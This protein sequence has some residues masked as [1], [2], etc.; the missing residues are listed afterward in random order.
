M[1]VQIVAGLMMLGGAGMILVGIPL[2][3]AL[4]LGIIPIALGVL[5]IWCALG[6]FK[7]KKQSYTIAL[8]AYGISA[9][10]TLMGMTSAAVGQGSF[11]IWN[12]AFPLL[13][14]W[15]LYSNREKFVN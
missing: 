12:L 1:S 3:L 4:G 10:L 13:F 11:R 14:A 6:L 2:L 9:A 5:F 7:M 15:V 8:A